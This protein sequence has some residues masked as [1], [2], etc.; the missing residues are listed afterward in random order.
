MQGILLNS[1]TLIL[2]FQCLHCKQNTSQLTYNLF[3]ELLLDIFQLCD[4][5]TISNIKLTNNYFYSLISN[6]DTYFKKDEIMLDGEFI[7]FINRKFP[8]KLNKILSRE[9]FSDIVWNKNQQI[10]FE[11]QFKGGI[12]SGKLKL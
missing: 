5:D 10:L 12:K 8:H 11:Q 6:Y 9:V 1:I 4:Q 3:P 7:Y 2:F